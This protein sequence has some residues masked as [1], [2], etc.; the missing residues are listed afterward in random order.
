MR[1]VKFL[2]SITLVSASAATSAVMPLGEAAR[3][4]GARPTTFAADMSPSGKKIVYLSAA[5]GSQ[6]TVK[7]VDLSTNK[8]TNVI[9]SNGRPES[10]SW[11][12]FAGETNLICRYDGNIR[13]EASVVGASRLVAI[14]LHKNKVQ[15]LGVRESTRDQ[16]LRQFDGSVIDWLP[17]GDGASVLMARTHVPQRGEIGSN[18][19]RESA[20]GLGVDRLDLGSLRATQI[21]PARPQ[22]AMYMTDAHGMVRLMGVDVL[23]G[24]QLTGRRKFTYRASG[25]KGWRELGEFNSATNSGMWPLAIDKLTD[26]LFYLKGLNGRDALYSMKLDGSGASTLVAKNDHVDISGIARVTRGSPVVGYLYSDDRPRIEYFDPQYKALARSLGRALKDT[27]LISFDSASRDGNI[28]LVHGASDRNPGTYYVLNRA[29]KELFSVLADRD[30]L[31]GKALAPVRSVTYPA[32]DGTSIPAYL[33]MSEDGGTKNRPAV[34]LPHGGPS[35]RDEWGFDWI[36]QFLAA[37]G[38]VVIQPQYR[39]SAGFGDDFQGDN[40]FRNW[41][42][43]MGDIRDSAAYLVKE[44]IVDPKRVAIVGWS[45]GGYAALQ[46]AA[47]D[48]DRYKAVVA[49]APVTDL[50]ALRKDGEGFTNAKLVAAEIGTGP[51]LAAG[52][53][54]RNAAAI[55]APVLLVH[56]DLDGNVLFY[57]SQRMQAALQKNGTPVELLTLPGLEHQ[58]DDAEARTAMLTK[59]G[60]LLDRTIGS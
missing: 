46:S 56:G 21:E 10:F 4:F 6:T 19:N 55:K 40:A 51:D 23:N 38:Y 11:C 39:G 29:T 15:S 9:S 7:L 30:E 28:L 52:S 12:R 45:Y 49:I 18:L 44:G 42:M 16:G 59:I 48:P 22:A 57:H 27:P 26:S 60:E 53:P 33:T 24:Q 35:S 37:R 50:A 8:T 32:A 31:T 58:L 34:V 3:L 41:R 47:T 5:G 54:L 14:D 25:T 36:A 2:A 13:Y 1:S 43:A 17:D 20:G